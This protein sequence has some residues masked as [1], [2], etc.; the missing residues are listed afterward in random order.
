MSRSDPS[1][2]T[3]RAAG[4]RRRWRSGAARQPQYEQARRVAEFQRAR[5][6][7]AAVEIASEGGY[8]ASSVSGIV[9][10][11]GVSRRTFYELFDSREQ[12][13]LAGLEQALSEIASV[14]AP[15][16]ERESNWS[17]RL[18][19]VLVVLLALLE[20]ERDIAAVALDYLIGY[21]PASPEL[22]ARVLKR[23]RAVIEQG[24]SQA[25]PRPELSPLTA[26]AVLGSVLTIV[27]ARLR[28]DPQRLSILVN[29]LMWT[30]VLPYLGPAAATRELRRRVSEP[31]LDSPTL[32]SPAL[33]P[34]RLRLTYRTARVLEAIAL[35]PGASNIDIGVAAG[36]ADQGQMSRLLARLARLELIQ[37]LGAGQ[38][39]GAANAWHLT[40]DGRDF[41][42][43]IRRKSR[44]SDA[45]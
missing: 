38:P 5:L 12:C 13:L 41:E 44:L 3:T 42:S 10:R 15:V 27:R 9:A 26:E 37:N 29:Q 21:M 1:S 17:Q 32:A 36:I 8:E 22:R 39:K 23:L 40:D 16:Y 2:D 19:D 7:K 18:R 33:R 30:I 4:S 6:M 43:A 28:T 24:R 35:A 31:A 20:R 34:P 25:K 14:L 45:G 11:A